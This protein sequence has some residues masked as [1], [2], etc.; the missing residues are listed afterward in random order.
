MG[1]K[2]AEQTERMVDERERDRDRHH[3]RLQNYPL[4]IL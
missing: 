3:K 1:K 2:G 4:V